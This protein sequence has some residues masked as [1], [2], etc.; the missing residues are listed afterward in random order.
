MCLSLSLSLPLNLQS[1][2]QRLSSFVVVPL[3]PFGSRGISEYPNH[4]INTAN[5]TSDRDSQSGRRQVQV[6]CL[7]HVSCGGCVRFLTDPRPDLA[8]V[9]KRSTDLG[10]PSLA[11]KSGGI[12]LMIAALILLG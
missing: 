4:H 3:A 9:S 7:Q 10:D 11:D 1:L 6:N 8:N 2:L 5:S 12:G